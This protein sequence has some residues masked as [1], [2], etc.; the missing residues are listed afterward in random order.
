MLIRIS[1][2]VAIVAGLAAGVLNFIKVKEKIDI[3]VT[4]RNDWN[5]KYVAAD[6]ELTSTKGTL[7]KTEKELT[8]TKET[9][10]KTE[11]ERATAVAEAETQIKKA[12]ELTEKLNTT[13]RDRDDAKAELAAYTATGYR[14]EQIA[15]LGKQVKAAEDALEVSIV[16]KKIIQ[17][18]LDKTVARLRS[19]TEENYVVELNPKLRGKVL[20]ADPKWEFVVLNVGEDDGAE[21]NGEL[22]V[23]RDGRLVAKVII[24][25]VQKGRS[26]ANMIP[27]WKLADVSEGDQVIPA[28]PKS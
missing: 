4:E 7:A 20:V 23:S 6:N 17:R 16:E 22:L 13:I 11:Q 5:Q 25:D 2:I 9:L 26:I 27:G 18:E 1:L 21:L 14:P 15:A 3:V 19:L 12:T 28:H 10:A 8:N 24:K